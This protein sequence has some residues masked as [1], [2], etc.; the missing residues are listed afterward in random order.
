MNR[1]VGVVIFLLFF[2]AVCT[3]PIARAQEATIAPPDIVIRIPGLTNVFTP[4]AE[5]ECPE[6][7]SGVDNVGCLAFPWIGQYISAIY[8]F[9]VYA[10]T[11]L[12]AIVIMVAGFIWLTAGGNTNAIGSA[13]S[14]IGGAIM[15]LI[16]MLSSYTVLRL[17][18]PDLV[19]FTALSIP[20]IKRVDIKQYAQELYASGAAI[21][22]CSNATW[23]SNATGVNDMPADYEYHFNKA[24]AEF[25]DRGGADPF[26]LAAI[27]RQESEFITHAESPRGAYGIMQIMPKTAS[28]IWR[29]YPQISRPKECAG[30]DDPASG[31]YTKNCRFWFQNNP[32]EVIRMGAAYFVT[33][34]KQLTKCG[35]G[36]NPTLMAAGYNA[37]PYGDEI[38]A[39]KVPKFTETQKYVARIKG[40]QNS[41]CRA[42]GGTVQQPPPL[43]SQ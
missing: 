20:V 2:F 42:S 14:Y 38:C 27:A 8:V 19:R 29:H 6:N 43:L 3:A 4:A 40:Y 15:G 26:F 17:V 21:S 36:G 41:F 32:G 30:D 39:G 25:S 5:V 18:N 13:R 16:L 9:A 37:G 33:I 11:I 34:N 31:K 7:F 24:S 23:L 28:E 10:A 1:R 22:T 12:A 35:F